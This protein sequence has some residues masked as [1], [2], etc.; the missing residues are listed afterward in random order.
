MTTDTPSRSP[1]ALDTALEYVATYWA[2]LKPP[3]QVG[4]PLGNRTVFEVIEGELDAGGLTATF[5]AAG[6][7][8]MLV[9][10]DGFGRLDVRAQMILADGTPVYAYYHGF[11]EVNDHVQRWLAGQGGT[12]YADQYFRTSPRFETSHPDLAWLTQS[13]FIGYGRFLPD[14][15]VE[16]QVYRA[17]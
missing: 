2:R 10:D 15:G 14:F 9:G 17:R 3:L 6:A 16:Y 4:G 8:W 11:V 7:D 13:L 12:D 1:V 5:T